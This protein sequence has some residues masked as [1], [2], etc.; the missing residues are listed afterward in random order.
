MERAQ[1]ESGACAIKSPLDLSE[2]GRRVCGQ[3]AEKALTSCKSSSR[4]TTPSQTHTLPLPPPSFSLYPPPIFEMGEGMS[5]KNTKNAI[6]EIRTTAF[7]CSWLKKKQ[8]GGGREN[9]REEWKDHAVILPQV[10][11]RSQNNPLPHKPDTRGRSEAR[12]HRNPAWNAYIR[13]APGLA[14]LGMVKMFSFFRDT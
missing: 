3:G 1:G 5:R 4:F 8:R 2:P 7:R 14:Y 10:S 11:Q 6:T 13:G 12:T 9:Q